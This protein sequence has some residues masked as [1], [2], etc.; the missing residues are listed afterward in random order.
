MRRVSR[1]AFVVVLDACGVGALPDA[2][3]YAGDEGS[4]T[5]APPRRG[6]RRA[7]TCRCS[8]AWGSARSSRSRACRRRPH[9]VVHG[10]LHP[11]GPGQGVDHRPLGA[12]GRR[13]D[14]AAA[15]LPRRLPA[16]RRG[17]A[18]GADRAALL[19]QP[20]RERDR[21]HRASGA[22][23]ICSTGEV[24]LYTS[25]DS[26]LQLAAHHD[27][28]SEA[29]L[30][31]ACAAA[32]DVMTGEHAVGRVIARPFVGEPGA[33]HRTD[34]RKDFARRR[35]PAAP[36]SRSCR[37][38]GRRRSTRSARFAT[39][40]PASASTSTTPAPR[41]SAAIAAI[42]ELL[43]EL[44]GGLVFAN[45]VETDQVYGHRHD[46]EGF[47]RALREIDARRR[48]VAR[49]PARRGPAGAHRRPR[50]GPAR[51]AHR[52]HAR[53]RAAAG[54]LRRS[55]RPPPRRPAGRRRGLDAD[56]AGGP[57]GRGASG[58]ALPL[59]T[60]G[61]PYAV[62]GARASRGRD[63]PPPARAPR[64]GAR[65]RAPGH[66]RPALV[67]A[68]GA[69]GGRRRRPGPARGARCDA[70]ASTSCGSSRTR[71]SCSCTCA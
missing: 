50:R 29:E 7:A 33:F 65:R 35:R 27:V 51:T 55:G 70:A 60:R 56:V 58:L 1:R 68:A 14:G 13:A 46:V 2:A 49:P 66:R 40:S 12:H 23:T 32:R 37:D 57:A 15:D 22:S 69:R 4:N 18:R 59:S 53:A 71:P 61:A 17:E 25:A 6:R 45:L 62:C 44:D 16:R 41:T 30:L 9:P 24:I 48:R 42:G 3:E 11:L 52:P 20:P 64:R 19:R 54:H 39:S 21:G 36:T 10:R 8:G 28:L 34:G 26:V 31:A 5:L 43:R 47:H 67:P 63:D 38:A